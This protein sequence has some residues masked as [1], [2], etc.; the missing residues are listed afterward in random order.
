MTANSNTFDFGAYQNLCI[1]IEHDA[2]KVELM[3][4][5]HDSMKAC[6]DYVAAVDSMELAMPRLSANFEGADLREQ[7]EKYDRARRIAHEA[8]IASVSC[9]NRMAEAFGV[10]MLY[11]GA[12]E[13]R[14]EI[15]DFC[16]DVVATVFKNRGA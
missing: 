13:D 12:Q 11:T 6:C 7:I 16:C 5:L 8:A 4:M 1:C 15:A 9:M 10:A 14:Y 2:D 3:D